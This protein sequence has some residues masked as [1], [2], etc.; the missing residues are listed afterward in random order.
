VIK[1]KVLTGMPG[2]GKTRKMIG[3]IAARKGRYVF[4]TSLWRCA[5]VWSRTA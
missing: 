3:D 1:V 5:Q 2:S 4:A